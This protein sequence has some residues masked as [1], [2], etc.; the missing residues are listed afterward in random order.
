MSPPEA[1]PARQWMPSARSL[2]VL[3]IGKHFYPDEGGVETVTQG[4][5]NAL[6]LEDIRADVLCFGLAGRSYADLALPYSVF[7]AKPDL[8]FGN[9]VLSFDFARRLRAI[10]PA[11]DAGLV[12][13]PNPVAAAAVLAIW[14]K[15][16]VLLWHAD[17]PQARLRRLLGPLDRRLI[18]AADLVISPTPA[19]SDGSEHAAIMRDKTRVA[20]FPFDPGRLDQPT[21]DSPG[22]RRVADFLRG[23]PFVLAVGR[24]VPYKGFD[25]LLKAARRLPA[26]AAVVIVGAGPLM[27]AMSE[28]VAYHELGGKVLLA[29]PVES[30]ALSALYGW[31]SVVCMPS[32]TAAEMYGM[33]Q[34]EAMA[35]GKP[36]VSTSIPRSGVPYVNR[37]GVSG[38]LVEPGDAGQLAAALTAILRDEALRQQLS[39]GAAELFAREHGFRSAGSRY[40][41]ILREAVALRAAAG[42]RGRPGFSRRP[43][44]QR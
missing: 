14:R 33:V 9:K 25:I 7:R 30:G 3:Q 27:G 29:G 1:E 38:L 5:S 34:V 44:A 11:Y 39:S 8:Q 15:P 6:L 24:L 26:E 43:G 4:I 36:I 2:K 10:E 32:V 40:A 21:P 37:H 13:L 18:A 41:A 35:F 17:I 19:H 23:R 31:S 16:L 22:A 42:G 28:Q 12:H 20:A